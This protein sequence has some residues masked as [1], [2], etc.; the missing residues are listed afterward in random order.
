MKKLVIKSRLYK[1][2]FGVVLVVALISGGILFYLTLVET[3]P[4]KSISLF[5]EIPLPKA[6]ERIL[7]FSPHP[8]DESLAAGGFIAESV[9]AGAIVKIVLVTDGNKHGKK[10][11]R[12]TEF[13]KA[14][15]ALG[16][17]PENLAYLNY[18]DGSL[19]KTDPTELDNSLKSQIESFG[20]E[21]IV[22]PASLDEH[23][24]HK[25]VG[26]TV[27]EIIRNQRLRVF[28]YQYLVHSNY[29]P[30]PRRFDLNDYLLPPVKILNTYNWNK[31]MLSSDAE[32]RK[33]EAVRE[34]KSQ[35]RTPIL[36]SL[37]LSLVRKNELFIVTKTGE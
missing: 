34:Y 18:P 25:K 36:K 19:S 27:W 5:D 21:I 35:L 32:F 20:P 17:S 31:L 7:V 26:Q 37:M 11:T 13:K 29:Y 28:S 6:G 15:G 8:D 16:V 30:Q 33:N 10:E 23:P 22:Y 12:Y 14:T 9:G 3:M 2:I 24:D 4:Q 1:V